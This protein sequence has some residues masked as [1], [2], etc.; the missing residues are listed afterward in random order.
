MAQ[1]RDLVVTVGY[2][3]W[4]R[5]QRRYVGSAIGLMWSL[6]NPIASTI[7]LFLVFAHFMRVP[8]ENYGLHLVAGAIPW[9][10][11]S[12][13]LNGATVSLTSRRTVLQSAL[14]PPVVFVLADVGS[15]LVMFLLAYAAMLILAAIVFTPPTAAIVAL[16]LAIIP[17]VVL[18]TAGAV[19]V[20]FL[21]VRFR[22]VPHVL[23]IFLA[24]MFWLVPIVYSVDMVPEPYRFLI[25]YNPFSLMILPATIIVHGGH[26]PSL[27]LLL[28]SFGMAGIA[29]VVAWRVHRAL[30]SDLVFHL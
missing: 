27:K 9:A 13:A 8:I 18:V 10:F 2:L 28:A 22:D 3:A 16:P 5:L 26:L 12:A 21:S 14:T 19:A 20:A 6:L 29:C 24:M 25:N 15:E 4:V 1:A 30:R 17:L 23:Q 7:I 11:L